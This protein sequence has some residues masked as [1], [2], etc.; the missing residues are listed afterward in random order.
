MTVM[1]WQLDKLS[2]KTLEL[3]FA[4][5]LNYH[6]GGKLL[7]FGLTQQQE[8]RAGYDIA[9]RIGKALFVVQMKA[10]NHVLKTEPKERRFKVPHEQMESMLKLTPGGTAFPSRSV[11]YAFPVLGNT[12]DLASY[13]DVLG[14]TWLC[15]VADLR[16]VTVPTTRT[17]HPRKDGCHYVNVA[18]GEAPIAPGASG[19]AVFHSEPVTVITQR[20]DAFASD[21]IESR[22]GRGLL[23]VMTNNN[24]RDFWKLC[25][26][27]HR[28]AFGVVLVK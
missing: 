19:T 20:G 16:A 7:W 4:S 5:Q 27:F 12:G 22:R 18:P 6:C 17:G 21:L 10:S 11:F 9:T 13:P 24:F 8:A 3:N 14:N 26:L 15:D 25:E 23:E 1:P 2:E 28:K